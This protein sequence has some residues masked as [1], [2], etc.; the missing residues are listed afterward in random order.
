MQAKVEKIDPVNKTIKLSNEAKERVVGKKIFT[1]KLFDVGDTI[2]Y[3]IKGANFDFKRKVSSEENSK[4]KGARNNSG[5]NYGGN[6]GMSFTRNSSR[7]EEI[8]NYPYNFVSFGDEKLVDRKSYFDSKGT[9]TGKII[10]TLVN[11]TPLFINGKTTKTN[12]G[13]SLESFLNED[14][15][16]IIPSSSLKGEVRNI[17]EVLTNSCIKNVEEDRLEKR[18]R[19]GEKKELKFGIIKRLP[20][21]TED[22]IIEEA[23]KIKVAKRVLR[24]NEGF[25][26]IKI[27][28]RILNYLSKPIENKE[29]LDSVC[30]GGK[31]E[32]VLWVSSP[33]FSKKYEKIIVAKSFTGSGRKIY[34]LSYDD[35]EDLKYLIN[36]RAEREEKENKTF[37]LKKDVDL[38]SGDVII[39]SA[40]EKNDSA[41]DLAFSEI[42][43]LRY[44][45]S[46]L[47]LV[48]EAFKPCK[49]I[50]NLCFACRLFGSTGDQKETEDKDIS[51][52]GKV[53]FTDAKI[54]EKDAQIVSKPVLLKPLGE[55]HPSLA[56]FYLAEGTYDNKTTIRGRKFYWHHKDKIQAGKNYSS[57]L[58]SIADKQEE[59]YNASLQFMKPENTF[60]FEVLFKNLTD[61]ELGILIYSLELEEKMLHKL[62]K[63]K[64]FGFGSCKISIDKFL[65]EHDNKYKS[66]SEI[67]KDADKDKYLETAKKKYILD[68]RT[69]IKELKYI[70][71]TENDLDF[72]ESPY[73]EEEK[74]GKKNTLIW[75]GN[76]KNVTLGKILKK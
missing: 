32:A 10:C 67:Y 30:S 68:S 62:G 36:Q 71:S 1:Q 63:A 74:K 47:D 39:F 22:G 42:P 60:K 7:N 49:S 23:V 38:K 6:N 41:I 58:E 14:G 26:Q 16:Y 3:E 15:K 66:F 59:K 4:I 17:I 18:L 55:P 69:E 44:K 27:N 8:R 5:R 28:Q 50:K 12:K 19:A 70:L 20:S 51:C 48:P 11:K 37:Y 53:Y 65:L 24:E 57:Y 43:R 76:H 13:H 29:T 35:Y 31:E 54:E 33:I 75:F 56:R 61:E 64:A 9:N 40:D 72:S 45:Y 46:P 2:I 52:A 21:K 73:P 25:H 34:K